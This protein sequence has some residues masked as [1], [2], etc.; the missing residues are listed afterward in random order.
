MVASSSNM[1]EV[2]VAFALPERQCIV[3]LRVA[4]GTTAREAVEIAGLE[5]KFPEVSPAVFQEADLGIFGKRLR[6]PDEQPLKAGD[7]VEVYRPLEL[8]PKA[9]RAQRAAREKR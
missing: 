6:D 8:D 3:P 7:R 4:G 5:A 1:I 2:E 9:A